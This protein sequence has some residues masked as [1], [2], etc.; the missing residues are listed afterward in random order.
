MSGIAGILYL[1]DRQVASEQLHSMRLAL[2]HRG[3][4]GHHMWKSGHAGLVHCQLHTTPESIGEYL[5]YEDLISGLVITADARLDNR[6]DL[7]SALGLSRPATASIPDSQLILAAYQK[8]GEKCPEHLL[9]DFV[10]AIWDKARNRIFCARDHM[11][12]KPFY[13]TCPNTFFA[14][15][16]EIKGLLCLSEVRQHIN[17]EK[18]A[19][20]LTAVSL[21]N[22][23][24]FYQDILRLPPGHTLLVSPE[25]RCQTTCYWQPSP[26][27]VHFSNR[28][29]YAEAFREIFTEAV[30]CRLRSSAPVGSYLSGGLDSSSIVS[31]AAGPLKHC[32]T[33][34]LHIFSGVFD[35]ITECD[36]RQYFQPI[37][38]RYD[39]RPH[40]LQADQLDASL[41]FDTMVEW[42]DEPFFAPHFFMSWNLLPMAQREGVRVLLDGHDGDSAVS[43]GYTLLP[44]LARKGKW[45]QL[46]KEKR[47]INPLSRLS[48]MRFLFRINKIILLR[49]IPRQLYT[50]R[51]QREFLK[52]TDQLNPELIQKTG[53]KNRLIEHARHLPDVYQKEQTFHLLNISQPLHPYALEFLNKT[54]ARFN[55]EQRF[56]FFDKRLIEFCLALPADQKLHQGLNR[57]V[58]RHALKDILPESISQRKSK[59]DFSANMTHSFSTQIP[60]WLSSSLDNL[61][62]C[63]YYFIHNT[64]LTKAHCRFNDQKNNIRQIELGFILKSLSLAKW[65]QKIRYQEEER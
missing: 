38:D 22:S 18:I 52:L 56:P 21:D 8:W 19:D 26:S 33:G 28:D 34:P 36:E 54:A 16:S 10:F 55:L 53:I 7:F 61:P 31:M 12:I 60:N 49:Q 2:A 37:L 48:L 15:A 47:D 13:Y 23:S 9:G 29:E 6:E 27:Q 41:A 45:W 35:T 63:S 3:P 59:T 24:T 64:N 40:F 46:I 43:Y 51:D 50:P 5:P 62:D 57:H 44:E 25:K 42:E 65:L 1:N 58:V 39:I 30:R 14:F 20:F 11:G 17:K 4:D 32:L